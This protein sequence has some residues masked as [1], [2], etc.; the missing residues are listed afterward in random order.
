MTF[1]LPEDSDERK[2]WPVAT[3]L[4]EYFPDAICYLSHLSWVANE[5]HNPGEPM[6]WA[7]NKSTDQAN[8]MMRHFM[9]GDALDEDN[10]L[11]AGKVAWRALAR[12]QDLLEA[13]YD[14]EEDESD[15][16]DRGGASMFES[17]KVHDRG[18]GPYNC[19]CIDCVEFRTKLTEG[20]EPASALTLH[21]YY[22][23]RTYRG[24]A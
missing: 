10:M 8:T 1:I 3:F 4:R 21:P 12:L 9:E 24:R 5:Q 23:P 13:L 16:D 20:W 18:A 15:D 2:K 22:R 6:H 11:H 14:V 17:L 19:G 7:R